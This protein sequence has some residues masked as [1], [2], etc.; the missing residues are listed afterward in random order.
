[1]NAMKPSCTSVPQSVATLLGELE[2]SLLASQKA[3]L[4]GDVTELERGAVE[5][6]RLREALTLL[7]TSGSTATFETFSEPNSTLLRPAQLRILHLGRVQLALLARAQQSVRILA[8]LLAG[9][10]GDYGPPRNAG[11]VCPSRSEAEEIDPCR[12]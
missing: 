12:A 11:A 2:S 4:C 5:Q 6:K 9:T 8:N 10:A 7:W 1:M 3:L